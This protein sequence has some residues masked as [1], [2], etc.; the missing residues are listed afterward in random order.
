MKWKNWNDQISLAAIIGIPALWIANHWIPL[1]EAVV[2]ASIMGW[3]MVL[4]YY[5]RRREPTA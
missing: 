1:P 3:T 5:F 2:G 4:Q